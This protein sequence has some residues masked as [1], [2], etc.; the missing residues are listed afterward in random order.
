MKDY[1]ITKVYFP[2]VTFS[3]E[4]YEDIF[5]NGEVRLFKNRKVFVHEIPTQLL[6]PP[7]CLT[8]GTKHCWFPVGR[9]VWNVT[10]PDDIAMPWEQIHHDTDKLNNCPYNLIKLHKNDHKKLHKQRNPP[11]LSSK[12]PNELIDFIDDNMYKMCKSS[13]LRKLR[14]LFPDSYPS[15]SAFKRIFRKVRRK[16]LIDEFKLVVN[17]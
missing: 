12:I 14:E 4:V 8:P 5:M 9:V 3:Y 17:Q 10:H 1:H 16:R 15:R 6:P 13:I 2:G 7:Y 11:T